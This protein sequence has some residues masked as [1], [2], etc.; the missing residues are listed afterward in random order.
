MNSTQLRLASPESVREWLRRGEGRR[1]IVILSVADKF[2]DYGLVAQCLCSLAEP[3]Q[4]QAVASAAEDPRRRRVATIQCMN[5][6]CRV[7]G[8]GVEAQLLAQVA[9]DIVAVSAGQGMVDIPVVVTR[10]NGLIRGFFAGISGLPEDKW[11]S[12][13]FY[14][15]SDRGRG[16]EA[17][18]L[19]FTTQALLELRAD[20]GAG[21]FDEEED[22]PG[23]VPA[24]ATEAA[25]EPP[26]AAAA[27][28]A[29]ATAA[30]AAEAAAEPRRVD[31][32]QLLEEIANEL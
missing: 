17:C 15:E 18:L 14:Y 28:L 11:G 22:D 10:R 12:G 4:D 32:S 5:M 6:S 9:R 31:W 20:C 13:S 24:P 29:A 21:E 19:N 8:R 16:A 1:W 27:A 25:I 30:A 23:P 26:S 3:D 7:L 2:G